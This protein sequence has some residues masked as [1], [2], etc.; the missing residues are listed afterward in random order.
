MATVTKS[1]GTSSR[2][3]STITAWDADLDNTL[4]YISGDD[5]VGECY[6]DSTFDESLVIDGG[7]TIGLTSVTLTAATSE[8]HDGTAGTG[9]QWSWTGGNLA[10]LCQLGLTTDSVVRVIEY[11]DFNGNNQNILR[12]VYHGNPNAGSCTTRY[13]IMRQLVG[14]NY[15]TPVTLAIVSN[16]NNYF[17]NN[18]LYNCDT[19]A[20]SNYRSAVGLASNGAVG[21]Q[22]IYNCTIHNIAS[23]STSDIYGAYGYQ[24]HSDATGEILKNTIITSVN[25]NSPRSACFDFQSGAS[26]P[27]SYAVYSHNISSDSSATGTGS[28]TNKAAVDQFVSIVAGSEDLHLKSG[29]DAIGAGTDLGTTPNGVQYDIDGRDRDAEG[30]T[31]SIGADQFVEILH[32]HFF[33][34]LGLR[35]TPQAYWFWEGSR[36]VSE[37]EEGSKGKNFFIFFY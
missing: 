25:G 33:T 5:A 17:H 27:P 9:V 3:Y 2:D 21:S 24:S 14:V 28:L 1:I 34:R 29:S 36:T 16:R 15:S 11:I 18:I 19:T 8:R 35:A 32:R 13:S 10:T 30:D 23:Q 26:Q 12:L 20:S 37:E 31:W 4:V 7:I 6:N 22:E